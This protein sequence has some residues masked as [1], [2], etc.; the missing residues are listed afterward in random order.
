MHTNS[1]MPLEC[2]VCGATCVL[3]DVVDFNKSCEEARGRRLPLAGL[4]IYY[5]RC[6]GCRFCFSP[7]LASWDAEKTRRLVYNEDY[8][9]VDPDFAH[10]RPASN[11]TDLKHAFGPCRQH[12]VHL[13]YGGGA[14]LVSKILRADGWQSFCVDP[15]FTGRP[16]GALPRAN[17]I[18]AFEVFEHHPRPREL[19]EEVASMLADD[20]MILFSTLVSDGQIRPGE[21][22]GWWY[23]APRNGHVSLYSRRSLAVLAQRHGFGFASFS[24]GYHL[25]HRALPAWATAAVATLQVVLG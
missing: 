11:A 24:D 17:L 7:E 14:G 25:F 10:V 4:P 6:G 9:L 2:P 5:A 3:L 18:T 21:R 8:A 23:A 19:M 20:G 16:G 22:L 13:D 12:I 15:F 1:D